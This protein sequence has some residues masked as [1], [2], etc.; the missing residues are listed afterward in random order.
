MNAQLDNEE[1]RKAIRNRL[2]AIREELGSIAMQCNWI[3]H[4][5]ARALHAARDDLH[6]AWSIL[7]AHPLE[8]RNHPRANGPIAAEFP[9]YDPRTL[10]ADLPANW[11]DAS[12]HNDVC[13]I[14]DVPDCLTGSIRVA[15]DYADPA[16]R[17]MAVVRFSAWQINDEEYQIDQIA[18]DDFAEI[19]AWVSAKWAALQA[20][21]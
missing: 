16:Q 14:F 11:I 20:A 12:W 3:D 9:S 10:P 1:T 5:A 19:L 7:R 13:P 2:Q 17:E 15:I 21:E 18:S 4:D 6:D 8:W